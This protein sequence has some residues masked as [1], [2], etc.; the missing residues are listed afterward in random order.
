MSSIIDALKKSDHNR[1]NE[2][3]AQVNQIQFGQ[4]PPPKSRRGFWLLVMLLLL[5]AFGTFSWTQGWHHIAINKTKNI[6]GLDPT[7]SSF[8]SN[9]QSDSEA[10]NTDIDQNNIKNATK[11]LPKDNQKL[12]PPQTDEVKAKSLATIESNTQDENQ[13]QQQL[14]VIASRE[15]GNEKQQN[16]DKIS[17]SDELNPK[18]NTDD[19]DTVDITT[20]KTAMVAKKKRNAL[21]PA[22]KQD[23]LLIHQIDFEIRKNIPP[24]KLNIHIFDPVP[25]NRMVVLNG[26]KYATGDLIEEI[27]EV[28]EINREGVVLNFENIKF[29]IPK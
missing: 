29:L 12:T 1:T 3:G 13:K 27:V 20:E 2:T 8:A 19:T 4:E 21:E 25:E 7:N 24:V 5:V 10:P 26:V 11:P 6:L 28:E 9:D 18:T 23:Y 15:A 22:L 14:E 17:K 16:T